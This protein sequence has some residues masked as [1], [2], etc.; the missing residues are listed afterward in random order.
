MRIRP[1]DDGSWRAA[2][3]A[4]LP[5]LR[6]GRPLF[7]L[8]SAVAEASAWA[9]RAPLSAW[10]RRANARS[11]RAD[12][13]A[14]LAVCG[15]A[16]FGLFQ[17]VG[18]AL[19]ESLHRV[20]AGSQAHRASDVS[21]LGE[22]AREAEAMLQSP[23]LRVAAWHDLT[24]AA[25]ADRPDLPVI[26]ERIALLNAMLASAGV[27]PGER[28]E[29]LAN[30]LSPS[31]AA[32][33]YDPGA[34]SV[35]WTD[36]QRLEAGAALLRE[37][38]TRG[39]CVAWLT[40]AAARLPEFVLQMG[41]V[42]L[43]DA[44]WCIA[45][46][47]GPPWQQFPYRDELTRAIAY[48]DERAT[49]DP[50]AG[51]RHEVLARVDLGHR[52]PYGSS[53]EAAAMV[54]AVVGVVANRTGA[55]SWRQAGFSCLVVDEKVRTYSFGPGDEPLFTEP[56][57][58]G[59][60]GFADALA[61]YTA[62][63]AG[64]LS[65]GKLPTDV[66]EALRLIGEAGQA[67]SRENALNGTAT[68]AEQTVIVLQVASVERLAAY[69]G[70]DGEAFASR[71]AGEWPVARYRHEVARA[72]E[73]CLSGVSGGGDP[74]FHRVVTFPSGRRQLNLVAAFEVRDQLVAACPDLF[75]RARA[76]TLLASIGDVDAARRLLSAFTTE[77]AVLHDRL[78]R[79]RNGL[80]HGN[81]I[82]VKSVLSVRPFSRFMVDV[83]LDDAIRSIAE[84]QPVTE[85]VEGRARRRQATT[86]AIED[87]TSF[88]RLWN[89][90]NDN[91]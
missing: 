7:T 56:D 72:V 86:A 87:G 82:S 50:K 63:L 51:P 91:L 28:F 34:T 17:P 8:Y 65:T 16:F 24:D 37:P 67:D 35:D 58:Y 40:F 81:P 89:A 62:E 26:Q 33:A 27:D 68:I 3:A 75:Q 6:G 60:H 43:F 38:A 57:H 61:E 90:A 47:L 54:R 30:V 46:A 18:A 36:G 44:D 21:A 55:P 53:E 59:M 76:R 77:A 11:M 69:A 19:V 14:G 84:N 74:L 32:L 73:W 5:G 39:H 71:L 83:A 9:E 15:T 4:A 23:S 20:A 48:D 31:P 10:D 88:Y 42:T 80:M 12:V 79:C 41:P 45:N 49:L 70:M 85:L 29:R 1:G 25:R 52:S 78:R 66:A 13:K 64:L 22:A 2:L